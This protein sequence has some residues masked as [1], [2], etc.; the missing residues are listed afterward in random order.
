M[1]LS[2]LYLLFTSWF[3]SCKPAVKTIP[4]PAI[5]VAEG[6]IIVES[7]DYDT[8]AWIELTSDD[9]YV[10]DIKY[11][12]ADNFVKE[13]V[14][15]CGRCFLRREAAIALNAVR[16]DLKQEGY[17]LKLFDCYRPRPVQQKL[18]DKVP[19]PNYVARPSEGSMHN[20]GAALDLTLTDKFGKELDLGTP[21]DFF[22]PQAH[23]DYTQ[24][25]KTV[26]GLR[27]RLKNVMESH[28]FNSIR[29]EWWHYSLTTGSYALED[30]QWSCP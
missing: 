8:S 3:I 17:K 5:T 29:T 21:Y 10:I 30:W 22:G 16:D 1:T 20:R 2:I 13:A 4:Q 23:H 12:T 19:N 7:I 15:P 25:S 6:R 24:L 27:T 11:A 14:Y 26:L 28:G 18:W 9:Q